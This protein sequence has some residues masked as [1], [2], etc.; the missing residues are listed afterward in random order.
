[1]C[2]SAQAAPLPHLDPEMTGVEYRSI[3]DAMQKNRHTIAAVARVSDPLLQ[4]LD[5]GKRNLDWIEAI[6]ANRDEQHKLQ[7]TTPETTSAYPIETPRFSNRSIIL[8]ELE[9]LKAD[10]PKA[11][12]DIMFG[13]NALPGS[14]PVDDETFLA[15]ARTM[16]KVYES[17]S[18]WLLEEPYLDQ[19]REF[20]QN[21]I[22]GYYFLNKE[23]DLEKKLTDWSNLDEQT[24]AKF[25]SWLTGECRNSGDTDKHCQRLL[26]N[27]IKVNK[28]YSYHTKYVVKAEQVYNDFFELQNPRP[29]VV[30]NHHTPDTMA[31]PFTDPDRQDVRDWFK[32]NVEDEY[33]LDNW[34]LQITYKKDANLAKVVFEPGVTPHVNDLG[35]DTITMDAN[36][37]LNEYAITWTI[38]HE[39]GHVLGFPD[40]YIEFYDEKNAVMVNY[41]LDVTN[42][43]CSRRGHLQVK[44]YEQLKKHY[45][46]G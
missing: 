27:A 34:G 21:D 18:R 44:H 43:M 19:Y 13:S 6:N 25:S 36:R 32:S 14:T 45:Y 42:L 37:Q 33:R 39:F 26:D 5:L 38:R 4:I 12:A 1:L 40:C 22:R 15:N 41:Q 9:K 30:W 7:L 31:M 3:F 20:A 2:L 10:M 8:N 46:K 11:M 16:N 23:T 17:A 24:Q 29:E 28:V 35:G